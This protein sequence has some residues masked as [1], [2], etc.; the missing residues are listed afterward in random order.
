[1]VAQHVIGRLRQ[2]VCYFKANLGYKVRPC[3]KTS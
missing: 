3:L 1:M 2:E